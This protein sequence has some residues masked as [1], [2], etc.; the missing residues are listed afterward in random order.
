[1]KVGRVWHPGHTLSPVLRTDVHVAIPVRFG[2]GPRFRVRPSPRPARGAG[3][4]PAPP[5]PRSPA[6]KVRDL[7]LDPCP[8]PRSFCEGHTNRATRIWVFFCNVHFFTPDKC[9]VGGTPLAFTR[10]RRCLRRCLHPP[11]RATGQKARK[12]C[13]LFGQ[14]R[15]ARPGRRPQRGSHARH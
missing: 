12:T 7:Q 6:S 11:W 4:A 1:M 9:R 15:P 2:Q 10:H 8:C 13:A 3:G 14:R 5:R